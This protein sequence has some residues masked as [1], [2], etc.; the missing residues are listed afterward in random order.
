MRIQFDAQAIDLQAAGLERVVSMDADQVSSMPAR[1]TRRGSMGLAR[2]GRKP[3]KHGGHP[4][5]SF[6]ITG[7]PVTA[8]NPSATNPTTRNLPSA[9][10]CRLPLL[11]LSG[12]W[13]HQLWLGQ[14]AITG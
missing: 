6:A 3:S 14:D 12:T 11:G 7:H 13:L 2:I 8:P 10:S 4:P 5:T 9:N 1:Y